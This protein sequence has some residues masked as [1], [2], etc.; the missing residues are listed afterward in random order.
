MHRY[1]FSTQL[2]CS[3][4]SLRKADL[5]NVVNVKEVLV[6]LSKIY[7]VENNFGNEILS[8]FPKKA[9]TIL[10]KMEIDPLL[11]SRHQ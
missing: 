10:E 5:V 1:S 2:M 9:R 8:E 7:V 6:H 3:S 4:P 11:K